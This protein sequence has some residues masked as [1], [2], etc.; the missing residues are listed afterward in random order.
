MS[1]ETI[2]GQVRQSY[3]S[4]FI[5]REIEKQRQASRSKSF[6]PNY[7]E[8]WHSLFGSIEYT[9][10]IEK[11]DDTL[12]VDL[13]DGTSFECTATELNRIIFNSESSLVISANGTLFDKSKQGIIPRVLTKWYSERKLYKRASSD[14]KQ[15]SGKAALEHEKGFTDDE[16]NKAYDGVTRFEWFAEHEPTMKLVKKEEKWFAEDS[17]YAYSQYEYYDMVQYI[18]KILLNSAYGSLLNILNHIIVS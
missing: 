6:E 5:N 12:T 17:D 11:T 9:K 18:K 10:I 2:V 4:E 15:L 14:C 3:T 8:A 1:P 16:M 13:N 7:T